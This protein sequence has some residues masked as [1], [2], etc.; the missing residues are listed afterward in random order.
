VY[1]NLTYRYVV[2]VSLPVSAIGL[3]EYLKELQGGDITLQDFTSEYTGGPVKATLFTQQQP[4]RNDIPFIVIAA[5]Y[6]DGSGEILNITN[7]TI[8]V[9]SGNVVTGVDVIGF[10]FRDSPPCPWSTGICKTQPDGCNPGVGTVVKDPDENYRIECSNNWKP[11]KPG[12]YKRV[13]FYVNASRVTGDKKT[14]LIVGQADYKYR[15]TTSQ[16]L[17]MSNAP[18][19]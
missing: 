11:L 17:T 6:N 18:P 8:T 5:I 12:E 15:K 7:F 19:Q 1:A 13:S 16:M 2:N 10:D 14:T 3:D 9:Y 4:A